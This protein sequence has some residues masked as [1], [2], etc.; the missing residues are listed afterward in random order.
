MGDSA[1]YHAANYGEPVPEEARGREIIMVDF[2]YDRTTTQW[3]A[4]NNTSLTILDH[5]KTAK[6]NL[7]GL[8][9]PNTTIVFDMNRSGAG[10]AWD[11]YFPTLLRPW[12]VDY[13]EDRDLWRW[14]LPSS[15]EVSAYIMMQPYTIDGW[16]A[17][18]NTQLEVAVSAGSIALKCADSYVEA[19]AEQARPLEF[20]GYKGKVV[21]A[22]YYKIS[23]LLN[24]ICDDNN[25]AVGWFQRGDG[26]F[27]FSL[28]SKGDVDVSAIA[29]T[30]G[31]GGHKNA[32][33]FEATSLGCIGL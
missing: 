29:K 5:H 9:I 21:N 20:H 1:D 25:L 15:K 2:S 24:Y 16:D 10:I 23:D 26:M 28:R 8:Y 19:L 22:P 31:G 17:L 7:E 33:G 32:A 4:A 11:Y 6:E 14:S 27:Q 3:L 12:L 30:Y 18:Y 13:V